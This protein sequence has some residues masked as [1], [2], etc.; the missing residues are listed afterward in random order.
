MENRIRVL[1]VDDHEMVRRGLRRILELEQDIE[2]V[3]EAG[4]AKEALLQVQLLSPDII[5][6]DIKMPE[7]SGLE[8]AKQLKQEQFA[9]K[10]IFVSMYHEYLPQAI[11]SGAAGYLVKGAKAHELV[12][13]VRRVHKGEFV[14]G[15]GV[16]NTVQGQ[17]TT[18]RFLAGQKIGTPQESPRSTIGVGAEQEIT[19]PT[20]AYETMAGDIA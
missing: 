12:S 1:V 16:M 5:F 7:I 19:S 8:V 15:A 13:A 2:V 11:E 6:M 17:D 4:N 10:I 20:V 9:G 14:F 3:G 18:F